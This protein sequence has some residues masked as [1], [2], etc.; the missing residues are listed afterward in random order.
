MFSD[1]A[2][3]DAEVQPAAAQDVEHGEV[4]GLAQR[5]FERQQAD[6][7]AES[8]AQRFARHRGEENLRAGADAE[9]VEMFFA[10]PQRIETEPFGQHADVQRILVVL[11]LVLLVAEEVEQREQAEFHG[12]PPFFPATRPPGDSPARRG[13]GIHKADTSAKGNAVRNPYV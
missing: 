5:V 13:S 10:E 11:N 9:R 2:A 3:T 7:G 6:G 4:F 12:G 8:D 1:Q